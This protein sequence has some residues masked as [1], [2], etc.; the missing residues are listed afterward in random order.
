MKRVLKKLPEVFKRKLSRS[1]C[2]RCAWRMPYH[3]NPVA[4]MFD[5]ADNLDMEA[6]G[7]A[8]QCPFYVED[9]ILEAHIKEVQA[10]INRMEGAKL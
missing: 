10:V 5:Y 1:L 4:C 2:Y 3:N 9:I 7:G 8:I 6:H